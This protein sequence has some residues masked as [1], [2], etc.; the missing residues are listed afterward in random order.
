MN[1]SV[2]MHSRYNPQR[3][4]ARFVD[5]VQGD[6]CIIVVTEPGESYTALELRSRFPH[7]QL[8]ALRYTDTQFLESD[9]LWDFVWRPKN[10][11]LVFF[12]VD[13]IPEQLLSRS[14]F[15]AWK[16]ANIIWKNVAA[17]VW[18]S[19][20]QA[21]SA[22]KSII[23]TRRYFGPRWFKN[24]MY[25]FTHIEHPIRAS[26]SVN[27][28]L[29]IAAGATANKTL[30]NISPPMFILAAS[31]A[32]YALTAHN[33]QPDCCITTD[34]GFW[35]KPHFRYIN[36]ATPV[37][38]PLEAALPAQV[39]AENPL[40]IL[41]YG[42]LL[43]TTLLNMLQIPALPAK[44]NG[45]VAGTA[46]ELLLHETSNTIY[47]AGL[48]LQTTQ[49]FSH[50]R[51]HESIVKMYGAHTRFRPLETTNTVRN[52]DSRSLTTYAQW[53]AGLPKK[54]SNR[55]RRI[56]NGGCALPNIKRIPVET[57]PQHFA[58]ESSSWTHTTIKKRNSAKN[59]LLDFLEETVHAITKTSEKTPFT[60]NTLYTEITEFL[61]YGELLHYR[62]ADKDSQKEMFN[63]MK[64]AVIAKLA[65]AIRHIRNLT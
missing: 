36:P 5:T 51:P 45:T 52:F 8:F 53:F 44:R 4:A 62:R 14:V 31:S 6:P 59:I 13:H 63:T 1:S 38:F 48:D 41:N 25:N 33:I 49:G 58:Q 57:L 42:S 28:S 26:F 37:L 43:E 32:L 46:I 56:G 55:L 11:N 3:E 7:A 15:L 2:R 23:A 30:P 40:L 18:D 16:P 9:H 39:L 12:L 60:T 47:L 35:A 64:T 61:A 24:I 22:I 54:K 21:V 34:G 50:I 19:I 29:F 17:I 10:G 20:A 27:N 65:A